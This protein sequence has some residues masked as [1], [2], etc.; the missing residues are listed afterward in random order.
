MSTETIIQ[1]S[2]ADL[3][4]DRRNPRLPEFGLS[5]STTDEEVI[6]ILWDAMD[7]R[8][9]V[10]SVAASGFFSH[11]PLIVSPEHGNNVVIEGNRRLAAVRILLDSDIAQSLNEDIPLLS[12]AERDALQT[13][14]AIIATRTD[15]WRYLGFKHVNGPAKWSSYAKSRY[16]ADV[17]R[18]YGASLDDIARQIG[19]THRTVQRLYRGLMVIEQAERTK[20][21]D[22][23][24]RWR[25]HFSFSHIYTGL[26]YPGISS[27]LGMNPEED[28]LENP[29]PE[30]KI[31]ELGELL[32]WLYGSRL[33]QD[34]PVVESQN[35]D[36][37]HLDLVVSSGEGIAALRSGSGLA[38]AYEL[39]RPVSTVFEESLLASKRNLQKAHGLLSTGYSGSEKLFRIADDVAELAYDLYDQMERKQRPR[40]RLRTSENT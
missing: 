35:P 26:G 18:T 7:V 38:I 1:M 16:I 14:P 30:D 19:D 36:L 33:S 6:R 22:R 39:S 32:L 8:E 40:K 29:V 34:P 27:F 24:N 37:R 9:L 12:A 10:M 4:F 23:D 15:S 2:V 25:N 13:L 11:E 28:E 31:K 20:V 5:A 3:V 21:F 17:H